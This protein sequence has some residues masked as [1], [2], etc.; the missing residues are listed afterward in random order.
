MIKTQ[1][2]DKEGPSDTKR[3]LKLKKATSKTRNLANM[4]SQSMNNLQ[5]PLKSSRTMRAGNEIIKIRVHK[6]DSIIEKIAQKNAAQDQGYM[7]SYAQ[8]EADKASDEVSSDDD[9]GTQM[10]NIS[11]FQNQNRAVFNDN[12]SSRSHTI[13]GLQKHI[14]EIIDDKS[15][16]M[17]IKFTVANT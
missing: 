11:Q 7:K 12:M 10:D 14:H 16:K 17:Q 9:E 2:L 15:H 8:T 6:P 13:H 5:S 1:V 3:K 4:K